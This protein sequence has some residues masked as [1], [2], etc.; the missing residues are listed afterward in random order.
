[1][2]IFPLIADTLFCGLAGI[3]TIRQD[4]KSRQVDILED[5]VILFEHTIKEKSFRELIDRKI[6]REQYLGGTAALGAVENNTLNL[7]QNSYL[8]D[9]FFKPNK[10]EKL[11]E[12]SRQMKL[13]LDEEEKLV[14][15]EAHN[16]STGDMEYVNNSLIRFRDYVWAI[17]RDIFPNIDMILSLSGNADK[18][19]ISREAFGRYRNIN[20]LLKSLDR[21]EVRGRDSAGVEI[22][23]RLKEKDALERAVQA[24]HVQRLNDEWEQRRT[25]SD[26]VDGSIHLS[27]GAGE[28]SLP[29]ISFTYKR[30]SVTGAL[31]ENGKYLRERIQSDRLLRIFT[32]EAIN[33]EMYLGHTRWAS[34]GSIT[35]ENCHPV[36][37]FTMN[38]QIGE[39]SFPPSHKE[40]PA[41]GQGAWTIDVA[42]NGDI[43]NYGELRSAI[44]NGDSDVIDKRVT[45]DTKIIPL[46]IER[47]L[48]EGHKLAEA[49]R[50]A[51]ND[52]EG[53]HAIAMESN[54]EPDKVFLAL[55][56]SGQSLYIGLC[57]N[58]Y[59][60]SSELYGLV[61]LTPYFIKMDGESERVEGD[62]RTRGQI[63]VL[64]Q[65]G[66]DGI[67][68]IPA[69]GYDGEP[70]LLSPERIEKAEITTR[71]IDRKDYPHFLLKEIREAPLSVR[72]TLRGKY[73]I[74][75]NERGVP[76]VTFNLGGD[77][78]SPRLRIAL[79]GGF[80]KNIYVVGQGTAAV[81]GAAIAAALSQYLR[82]TGIV[83][84]AKTS[85]ELSG[86]SLT[87]HLEHAL[88]IS[89]TQSGTTTDTNRAVAMAKER[90][91]H[92]IAIVNRRQSDITHVT[93]GVFYTSDGRDIE[94]SVASTKA[95]YSQIVAG[96]ILALDFAQILGAM[97][98]DRIA[99]E[100]TNL[101][102]APDKMETVLLESEAVKESVWNIV[103]KKRY[104][105][106]V[107]SG[108]NKVAADEIRIKLS[109]LCY[110]TISSDIVEDKKH[111]D[112]SSEPLIIVCSAGNPEPVVDDIVKDVAIF[113]AHAAATIVIAD[114]GETRFDGIADSVIFVPRSSFPIS[115]I[116]N[117]LAGH[118]GGYYAACSINED[119]EI[120]RD[121]RSRLSSRINTMKQE[122]ESLFETVADTE[123]HKII[124]AF[125]T[126]FHRRRNKGFFSSLNVEVASDITL[127]LKYAVGK[128][129][130]EDFWLEY[131][132]KR[133]SSS[134]FDM[135][136]ICLGRAIDELARPIDA[137][138]HQAKTVTV[139]TSR[140]GEMQRGILFDF[141]KELDFS[142]EN[143]TSYDGVTVRRL[144]KAITNIRGYTLY[145]ISDL[146]YDGKPT[147]FTTISINTRGGVAL[148][149][150]SRLEGK[151]GPLR[152]TKRN[153]I[154]MGEVYAGLGKT[155]KAP[156]AIIPLLGTD[157]KIRHIMLLHVD[158]KGDLTAVEKKEVLGNK[159]NK[160][161]NLIN[162]YNVP[163][164]DSYLDDI[165]IE[166]LLGEGVDV[167]V[168]RIMSS[169]GGDVGDVR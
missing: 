7:K 11:A 120:F 76:E 33:S 47:Y 8:E 167:I 27:T 64:N 132:E 49:F 56:G 40:Y 22:T 142:L 59:I 68:G 90:G 78:I 139:G 51:L 54:L 169:R 29:S 9:I 60:F 17:E 28:N 109:E 16:F 125:S 140:K 165:P 163:W 52:F 71:D 158:F 93:D 112:L 114:E 41:Y 119:G 118:L 98:D 32:E 92:L 99:V 58:Q 162:E 161:R 35:E 160:I 91:A 83:I 144:Q 164:N 131:K 127:L 57:D 94:M 19:Y 5:L 18:A 70:I 82:G 130:L 46:Q 137:I 20:L 141:L 151:P 157:H 1:M 34:V 111:I 110:K 15:Q 37:N 14:E 96:F 153:I 166:S 50:L 69:C 122:P 84:E 72:K 23:F 149:M 135:L 55:R 128:L 53:S 42:L 168:A 97:S 102:T 65:N 10:L 103:K 123:L 107:G 106:V 25:P 101:E 43:D 108:P 152:G 39:S 86:F 87:D 116:L 95:F 100:L 148:G 4:E 36:N 63:F 126:E 156:I 38:L 146:N 129:P 147:E 26:L 159:C 145:D 62:S 105:A 134:P 66:N 81:A 89:V 24:I 74:S 77:V 113:K 45:T 6:S 44:E 155:D 117:T 115:V 67:G 88:I 48:Y 154:N 80:V 13:F 136:D 2:V 73:K 79:E 143:L 133:P 21:L 75:S 61:E 31:G 3:I 12:L 138:R 85:S 104:W 124:D 150:K 30:A 121:F